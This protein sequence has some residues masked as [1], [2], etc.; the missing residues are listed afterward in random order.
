MVNVTP[1]VTP[2]TLEDDLLL[3]ASFDKRSVSLDN[4]KDLYVRVKHLVISRL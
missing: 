4:L 1:V 2:I 3:R